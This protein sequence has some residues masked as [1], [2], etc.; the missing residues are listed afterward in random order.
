MWQSSIMLIATAQM[1]S[2]FNAPDI[3]M[4]MI[5]LGLIVLAAHLGGKLCARLRLSEVTGQLL[6]GAMVG[7]YALQ[8]L[9][10]IPE[11]GAYADAINS[12]HYFIFVFLGLVAFGIG[13]ELH[14]N[15][16][17]RVGRS[18]FVICLIQ[19]LLSWATIACSFHFIAGKPLLESLLIGS[20]GIATA[21]AVTFVLMNQLNV[22]GRLRHLLGNMVVLDDLIEVVIFSLLIQFS[23]RQL[24]LGGAGD[25][26]AVFT[27]AAEVLFAL[28]VGG[29][30]YL[31][32]R[33]FVR[34]RALSLARDEG[35]H[36]HRKD[37]AF[38]QRILAEHPSPSVEILLIVL[39]VVSLGTGLAY[40]FHWP[41]LIT[42]MFAGFLVANF[43]SQAIFDSLKLD[44]IAPALNLAFFALIGANI[45][46]ADLTIH[47]F[48]LVVLYIGSRLFGKLFGTWL[49]CVIMRE[50]KA[51]TRYL[52][53]LM[54]PQAG[55]AAVEAVYAA[56]LLGRPE[57]SA[58]ILPAIVFFEVTGVFMVDRGLRKWLDSVRQKADELRLERAH[59]GRVEAVHMLMA[60]LPVDNIVLE[61][62]GAT[63]KEVIE[64]LVSHAC[65]VSDEHIDQVQ[66]L[67]L[68]GERE[69]LAPT[70][71]GNGLAV[72]HCRLIGI[73]NPVLVFGRHDKG[74]AFGGLDDEPCTLILLM[75]TCARDPGQHL[76]LLSALAQ[77]LNS[78]EVRAELRKAKT[79]E[80]IIEVLTQQVSEDA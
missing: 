41:F 45:S 63:K 6:G 49:G 43:H 46:M 36:A 21:P 71:L 74:I 53:T 29:A 15:R 19:G 13:E 32:L 72:P 14:F 25:H 39:A 66:A 4:Q 3:P 30:I 60:Y 40:H 57:I 51:I 26:G 56:A 2:V 80:G 11:G 37:E 34:K 22:E 10:L 79:P 47:T 42:A 78:D 70:G 75:L 58:I 64:E 5:A 52:P 8:M 77:I 68:L 44:N 54:L 69:Q 61:L 12:F 65:K 50:N 35:N 27:V 20:I 18:A 48:G 24:H 67:Q 55:V 62:N 28:L 38:L 59:S 9:H 17:K 1:E 33:T 7:P 23:R 73:D 76:R 16:V 31:F